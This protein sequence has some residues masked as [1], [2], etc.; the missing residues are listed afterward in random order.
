[1]PRA[2]DFGLKPLLY[3]SQMTASCVFETRDMF[4]KTGEAYVTIEGNMSSEVIKLEI[5]HTKM[6]NFQ[7][8]QDAAVSFAQGCVCCVSVAFV[9]PTLDD[10][11]TLECA[12]I[13]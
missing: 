4:S 8:S 11:C 1:M 12:T 3:V 7:L 6:G 2:E 5:L 9:K 13:A 10:E